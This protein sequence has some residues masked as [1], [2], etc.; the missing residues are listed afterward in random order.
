MSRLRLCA[1]QKDIFQYKELETCEHVF[2][3]RIA[4]APPLTCPYDGPYKV[5]SRSGRV[6]KILMKGSALN[7]TNTN[8]PTEVRSSKNTDC[9]GKAKAANTF[10]QTRVGLKIHTPAG[11]VQMVHAVVAPKQSPQGQPAVCDLS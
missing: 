9:S 8:T 11:F 4:I 6:K 7:R 3:Q 2:F 10:K 1:P 5:I